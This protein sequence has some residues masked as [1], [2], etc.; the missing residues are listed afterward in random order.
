MTNEEVIK[1][2]IA[3]IATTTE[4]SNEYFKQKEAYELAIKALK[5]RPRRE[6]KQI[7]LKTLDGDDIVAYESSCC[8]VV[9]DKK[10]QHCPKCNEKMEDQNEKIHMDL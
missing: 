10:Y 3:P 8:R 4:P 2:L 5:E 9:A 1:Y 6:W 7:P